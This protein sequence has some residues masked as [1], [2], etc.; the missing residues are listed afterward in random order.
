MFAAIF[1]AIFAVVCFAGCLA[2]AA[3]VTPTLA[4][5]NTGADERLLAGLGGVNLT[6]LA[7]VTLGVRSDPCLASHLGIVRGR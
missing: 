7:A 4:G 2:F 1:A 3:I 5:A 6:A